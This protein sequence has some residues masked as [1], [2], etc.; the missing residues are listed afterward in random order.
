MVTITVDEGPLK[1]TFQMH[2]GVVCFHSKYFKNLFE[3]GFMEAQSDTHAMPQISSKTFRMFYSWM[4]TDTVT[5]KDGV[6]DSAIN[7]AW[8]IRLYSFADYHM[9]ESLKNRV[10]E[11]F[12]LRMA[13]RWE[14]NLCETKLLYDLTPMDS[15]FRQLHVDILLETGSIEELQEELADL[16]RDFFGDMLKTC[17]SR[18]MV[19]GR[20]LLCS[21]REWY[22]DKKKTFCEKYHE[23][24]EPQQKSPETP[25]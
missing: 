2:R 8:L 5:E 15:P 9:A 4:Y 21:R 6:S 17:A 16:P 19:Y 20:E 18:N 13:E 1:A 7:E 23:H 22:E 14:D 24:K 3:G 12:F 10:A 11:L 25:A